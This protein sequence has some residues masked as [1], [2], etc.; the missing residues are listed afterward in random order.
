MQDKENRYKINPDIETIKKIQPNGI[1]IEKIGPGFKENIEIIDSNKVDDPN[2]D[3]KIM[4]GG[5]AAAAPAAYIL[6]KEITN[7]SETINN[8][9]VKP[10]SAIHD[11]ATTANEALKPAAEGIWNSFSRIFSEGTEMQID[12]KYI[13]K[14]LEEG[15]IDGIKEIPSKI[16]NADYNKIRDNI[17]NNFGMYLGG[18]LGAIGLAGGMLHNG[19]DTSTAILGGTIGGLAGGTAGNFLHNQ[20][21]KNDK[22][23]NGYPSAY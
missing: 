2:K 7:P 18:A 13:L 22:E 14:V 8:L 11:V 1:L 19:S 23:A 5:L 17:K 6:H 3:V 10:A 9:V 21:K 15:V 20:M 12:K 16:A 4:L